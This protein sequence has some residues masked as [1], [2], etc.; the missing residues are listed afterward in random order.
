VNRLF[1]YGAGHAPQRDEK[2]LLDFY[3]KEFAASHFRLV[4]LLRDIALS[5]ALYAVS[6]PALAPVRSAA[7][8]S[9]KD[10]PS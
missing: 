4:D 8:I 9:R 2:P 3:Q 6:P 7:V 10:D 1:S 5:D